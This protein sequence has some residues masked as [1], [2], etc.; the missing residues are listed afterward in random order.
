MK[1]SNN[2]ICCIMRKKRL[3]NNCIERQLNLELCKKYFVIYL[4]YFKEKRHIKCLNV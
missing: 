2:C 3:V 4:I 1:T